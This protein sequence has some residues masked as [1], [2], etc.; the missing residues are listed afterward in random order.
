[1]KEIKQISIFAENRPGKIE[2]LAGIMA[3]KKVNI[4]AINITSMGDFGVLK[5][6]VD[7]PEAAYKGLKKDGFAVTVNKVLG[8]EMDDR[9]GG[10]FHV[11]KTLR[12]N[13]V[14]VDNAYVFIPDSRKKA[15][16]VIET[17]ELARAKKVKG[18]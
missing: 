4:L 16:L 12:E 15:M 7:K 3:E 5:F 18:L 1:M 10:L 2:R 11:S 9:P 14:N 6:I 17:K 13:G 8:V